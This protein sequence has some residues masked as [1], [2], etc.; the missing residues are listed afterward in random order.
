M[1]DQKEGL[2]EGQAK[3]VVKERYGEENVQ[4]ANLGM[5]DGKAVWE[6]VCKSPEGALNYYLITFETGEEV[7]TVLGI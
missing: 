1:F 5:F 3:Q 6:V 2:T 4:K 7:N